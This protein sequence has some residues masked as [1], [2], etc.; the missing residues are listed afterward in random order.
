M[1]SHPPRS[2]CLCFTWDYSLSLLWFYRTRE[3]FTEW[4]DSR[5]EC[6]AE[7]ESKLSCNGRGQYGNERPGR[8]PQ[9]GYTHTTY[10]AK[11]PSHSKHTRNEQNTSKSH[12]G[13][14][15]HI[16]T[17]DTTCTG[18]CHTTDDNTETHQVKQWTAV[19]NKQWAT[20]WCW[21]WDIMGDTVQISPHTV[22]LHTYEGA[23]TFIY[24]NQIPYTQ[25]SRYSPP[26]ASTGSHPSWPVQTPADVCDKSSV[27][28]M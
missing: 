5:F 28:T 8:P 2:R 11:P 3:Y 14:K 27:W 16:R 25:T 6:W 17:T 24:R 21:S 19:L 12:P 22:W 23:H 20:Q 7:E 4:G 1:F 13:L 18:N 15:G 26:V 9:H 10:N